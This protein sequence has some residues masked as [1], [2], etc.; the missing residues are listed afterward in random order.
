MGDLRWTA[1]Q[2]SEVTGTQPVT[3]SLVLTSALSRIGI[4]G[5]NRPRHVDSID[6]LKPDERSEVLLSIEMLMTKIRLAR[7]YLAHD[8]GTMQSRGYQI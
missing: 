4:R 8:L 2:I 3:G 6:R 7:V 5:R 1:W